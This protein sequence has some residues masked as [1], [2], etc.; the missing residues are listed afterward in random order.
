[1]FW[2]SRAIG[3]EATW[4]L[5]WKLMSDEQKGQNMVDVDRVR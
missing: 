3:H 5:A 1:M 4:E 2:F